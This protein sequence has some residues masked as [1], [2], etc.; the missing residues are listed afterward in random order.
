MQSEVGL[1]RETLSSDRSGVKLGDLAVDS[2][3]ILV[4]GSVI[5]LYER[6]QF[7]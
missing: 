3:K 1:A 2:E 5:F 7:P 4:G 6:A